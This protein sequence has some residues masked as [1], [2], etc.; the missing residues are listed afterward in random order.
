MMWITLK[1]NLEGALTTLETMRHPSAPELQ[2]S[3]S[4]ISN[5]APTVHFKSC[6]ILLSRI[7]TYM[8]PSGISRQSIEGTLSF[9]DLIPPFFS[10]FCSTLRAFFAG[11]T[12]STSCT[13]PFSVASSPG[14]RSSG[15]A[16][17]RSLQSK[18]HFQNHNH[19]I[20]A[21]E[22]QFPDMLQASRHMDLRMRQSLRNY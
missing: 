2:G 16:A 11:L 3:M 4:S 22:L 1:I 14:S 8:C 13:S 10:F 12:N 17:A 19:V 18:L 20:H 15:S 7:R 21:Q 6:K 5:S 9:R